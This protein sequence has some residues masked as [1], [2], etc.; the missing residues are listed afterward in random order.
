MSD[1]A[2]LIVEFK[3]TGVNAVK[4]EAS[5]LK[6]S[7]SKS[8]KESAAVFTEAYRDRDRL[9]AEWLQ[10]L[11]EREA[12]AVV[13]QKQAGQSARAEIAK[14]R[15]IQKAAAAAELAE[16]QKIAEARK[17]IQRDI[18][19]GARR[20]SRE[21]AAARAD[22]SGGDKGLRV[23]LGAVAGQGLS[24]G[25]IASVNPMA[26]GAVAAAYAVKNV[27]SDLVAQA[28]VWEKFKVALTDIEGSA[29]KATDATDAL[30][31]LAK[32]PG[33]SLKEAEQTYLQF[34]A[35]EMEGTKAQKVIAAISNAV[36]LSGGGS[37]EFGRVNLQITQMLSKGKVLEEDLRVMRNSM[38]RLT[39]VM[40]EA[41][42]TTTAEGIRNAGI[43]AEQFLDK[44]VERFEKLPQATQTLESAQENAATAMSRLKAALVPDAAVKS[45][46]E[47][48]T[49]LLE[50]LTEKVT[51]LTHPVATTS[52]IW[53]EF[54]N[55]LAKADGISQSDL[56]TAKVGAAKYGTETTE[57]SAIDDYLADPANGFKRV[58][59]PPKA[60]IGMS[61]YDILN[62]SENEA[63][64]AESFADYKATQQNKPTAPKE[65]SKE[66]S[67]EL[68]AIELEN[69]KLIA[70]LSSMNEYEK[71]RLVII[72]EY[73]VKVEQAETDKEKAGLT[74]QKRLQ[75]AVLAKKY[76]EEEA[77]A[78]ASTKAE[79]EKLILQQ[80]TK[81]R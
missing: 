48:W 51:V 26:A 80:S 9:A 24:I 13:M 57:V 31:E 71:Q 14:T 34:R 67:K 73:G 79:T 25:G 33:I 62:I 23:A 38:P 35:L 37:E 4:Q 29:Q 8:A 36:A 3:S 49:A 78:V 60:W 20:A 22:A 72:A 65:E 58:N 66:E 55:T 39:T 52:S 5:E 70:Q 63:D 15:E 61:A 46:I 47:S 21:E 17:A 19:E 77:K 27:T 40:R 45:G 16:A 7:V 18:V 59:A 74:E 10:R 44:I 75:L 28:T 12:A 42:G 68:K 50:G 43:N 64:R 2:S 30:Y 53:E 76:K 32:R 56:A 54:K 81:R 69:A 41:F 1:T 6:Q 11:K